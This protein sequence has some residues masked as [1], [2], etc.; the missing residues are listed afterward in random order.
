VKNLQ[1]QIFCH[2]YLYAGESTRDDDLELLRS[3]L[4]TRGCRITLNIYYVKEPSIIGQVIE[5]T[6][7]RSTWETENIKTCGYFTMDQEYQLISGANQ[8][9]I[10]SNQEIMMSYMEKKYGET[11]TFGE[12]STETLGHNEMPDSKMARWATY[13]EMRGTSDNLPGVSF[14]VHMDKNSKIITDNYICYLMRP[15]LNEYMSQL[16]ESIYGP[17][18]VFSSVPEGYIAELMSETVGPDLSIDEYTKNIHDK[19][20]FIDIYLY[21]NKSTREDDL[22]ALRSA[23]EAR[24]CRLSGLTIYYVKDPSLIGQITEKKRD[25]FDWE[26]DNIELKGDFSM[27][28]R[29]QFVSSGKKKWTTAKD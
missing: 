23:L 18:Q 29:Y 26:K 5:E 3:A 12:I 1:G 28:Q 25:S 7:E 4:E 21:A 22:E 10:S 20:I 11:F 17:N 9:W 19:T 14:Q 15:K 6:R 27:D 24:G 8:K 16:I 2:I 13:D